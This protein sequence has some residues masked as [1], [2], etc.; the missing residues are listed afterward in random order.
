M[1]RVHEE[2]HGLGPQRWSIDRGSMFCIRPIYA[3]PF[4]KALVTGSLGIEL[5]TISYQFGSVNLTGET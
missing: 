4:N 2:V 5:S 1:D 3:Y